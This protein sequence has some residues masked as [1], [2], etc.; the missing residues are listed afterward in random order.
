MELGA[1]HQEL[2][3]LQPICDYF[4][5]EM[6]FSCYKTLSHGWVAASKSVPQPGFTSIP[7]FML[8]GIVAM[9]LGF[10][11]MEL[12]LNFSHACLLQI[13]LRAR[14]ELAAALKMCWGC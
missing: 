13:T 14:G 7:G 6:L 2:L 4:F 12:F 9:G 5:P 11:F 1:H 8:Q 3:L 10:R